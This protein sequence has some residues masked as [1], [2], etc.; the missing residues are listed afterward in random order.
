MTEID[1]KVWVT[2]KLIEPLITSRVATILTCPA[3]TAV[4]N[5]DLV[6]VAVPVD[7][8]L[9]LTLDVTFLVLPS[10]YFAVAVSCSLWPTAMDAL[11]EVTAI[12]VNEGVEL[13]E[14]LGENATLPQPARKSSHVNEKHSERRVRIVKTAPEF[15]CRGGSSA[16]CVKV[17]LFF[18]TFSSS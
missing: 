6:T 2:L 16:T 15:D 11:V 9:Q 13:G 3:A 7:E 10:L 1:T 18:K 8:E 14:T 4:I 5:P 12:E 17:F